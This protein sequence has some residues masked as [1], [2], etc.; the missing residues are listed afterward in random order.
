MEKQKQ[1]PPPSPQEEEEQGRRCHHLTLENK[2][3]YLL[4]NKGAYRKNRG[5]TLMEV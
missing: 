3:F 4:L 2:K 5:L 1:A